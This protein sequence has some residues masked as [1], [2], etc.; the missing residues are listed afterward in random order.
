M[1]AVFPGTFDPI[2]NGH[3][4]IIRRFRA[5]WPDDKLIIAVAEGENAGKNP[6]FTLDE[7]FSQIRSVT[8][9]VENI[10]SQPFSGLLTAFA[11]KVNARL[12][13]RGLRNTADFNY[14]MEM[15]L[16]NRQMAPEIET[17]FIPAALEHTIISSSA[18]RLITG[19]GGSAGW[20]LP[21]QIQA[22]MNA[23]QN[24]FI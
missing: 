14:E 8:N 18:A 23:R 3:L 24:K 6:M 15:A 5:L 10:E 17:V 2:T 12:I 11:R 13:I 21:E 20:M 1:T 7:R 22:E 9:G 16:Y 4:D 19:L